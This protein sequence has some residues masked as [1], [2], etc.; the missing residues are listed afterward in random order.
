MF[1][2]KLIAKMKRGAYVVNTARGK[3]V[4][5]DAIARRPRKRPARGL[6]G[7]VWFPQ[8]PPRDHVWRTIRT[9]A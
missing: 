1:D 3:I 6:C 7:D 9:K 2:E 5:R 8:P 4:N